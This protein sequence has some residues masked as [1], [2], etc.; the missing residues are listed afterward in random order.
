MLSLQFLKY[1]YPMSNI[2]VMDDKISALIASNWKWEKNVKSLNKWKQDTSLIFS[3]Q[4][5]SWC[6]L[7]TNVFI[8]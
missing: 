2:T 1:K 8:G 7:Y 4:R 6:R 3:V 5:G